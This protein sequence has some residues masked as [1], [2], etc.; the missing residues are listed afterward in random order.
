MNSEQC[1]SNEIMELAEKCGL[2]SGECKTL[3]SVLN[4]DS[5]CKDENRINDCYWLE[6]NG[7][8]GENDSRC[9]NKV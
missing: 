2:Y 4:S 9:M 6:P 8:E 1:L 7:A 5:S 3:C